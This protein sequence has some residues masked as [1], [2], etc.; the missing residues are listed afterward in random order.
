MDAP[1]IAAGSVAL[2]AAAIHGGGGEVWVMR[3]LTRETLPSTRLGGAG[4]T[5]AM[6]H[7][8]WHI[9]TFAFL[10]VGVA[11]ILAGSVLDGDAA[12]A[13]ARVA[14]SAFTGFA[15]VAIGLGTVSQG[16]RSVRAHPGPA[17]LAAGAALAWWGA[18]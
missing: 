7:V 15:A 14:A 5:R 4:M 11:L 12:R 16:T 10:I 2:I 13:V 6:I 8:T 3:N 17:V 1:L 9:V 18:V